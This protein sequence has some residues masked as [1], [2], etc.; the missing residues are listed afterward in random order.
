MNYGQ[1]L[2]L[3]IYLII[4]VIVILE[5]VLNK[6]TKTLYK[7]WIAFNIFLIGLV[8]GYGILELILYLWTIP[9]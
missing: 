3:I 2:I 8:I 7:W 4:T 5:Y 9:I 1:L 6:D